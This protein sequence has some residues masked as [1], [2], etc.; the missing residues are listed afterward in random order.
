LDLAGLEQ[1][2]LQSCHPIEGI[3]ERADVAAAK[4]R[5]EV[6]TRGVKDVDLQFLPTL[7]AQSTLGVAVSD[8]PGSPRPSWN[9]EAVLSV[10]LWDGG[11]RYG[12]RGAALAEE[13]KNVQ[14]LES[15]RRNTTIAVAQARRGVEVAEQSRAVAQEA[16]DL[17]GDVDRLTV[18]GYR[19][20]KGTSLDLVV[21][22]SALRQAE[23][24]LALAQFGVVRARIAGMLVLATCSR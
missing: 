20:G 21:A 14:Q 17:A 24:N 10:S 16:R 2:A 8:S 22:A 3:E 15:L 5:L 23:I 7:T 4:A 6:A 18:S 13:D 12:K 11:A 19:T 9:I 1:G